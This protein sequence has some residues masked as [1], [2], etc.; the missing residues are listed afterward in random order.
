MNWNPAEQALLDALRDEDH[1]ET[2]RLTTELD[3]A[4]NARK[5]RLTAF[6]SLL[7][8]ALYYANKGI[9]V[10]PLEPGVGY[11]SEGKPKGK[12]PITAHGLKDATTDPT[13]VRT[14]WTRTPQANIGTPT[15]HQFDVI[16]VD[17]PDG[18]TSLNELKAAGLVPEPL[19]YARTPRSGM[20]IYV[21]VSG[22]GNATG[23]LPGIDLRGRGGYVVAPPSRSA[24]GSW[25]WTTTIPD[26]RP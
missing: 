7:M 16:D 17:P 19:G 9:R 14:W 20:H 3:D 26:L 11:D 15:G 13:Q 8:S 23:I 25:E 2:E 6:D 22:D 4:E 24:I 1:T 18:W 10:F 5:A 12:K 21:P